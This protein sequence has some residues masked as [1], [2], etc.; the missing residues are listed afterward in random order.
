MGDKVKCFICNT[1]FEGGSFD[2]CPVCG[3]MYEGFEAELDPNEKDEC[4]LMSI[5]KAKKNFSEGKNIWGESLKKR[6]ES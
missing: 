4:N 3:W 5:S 2:E 1:E 6:G